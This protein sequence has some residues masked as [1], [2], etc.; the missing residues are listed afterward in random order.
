MRSWI[1][2]PYICWVCLLNK[3]EIS[4]CYCRA[5][6]CFW[7]KTVRKKIQSFS[8]LYLFFQMQ[9]VNIINVYQKQRQAFRFQSG[10]TQSVDIKERWNDR[11]LF[12]IRKQ[13]LFDLKTLLG[14]PNAP[15]DVE[16]GYIAPSCNHILLSNTWL[17][18][19]C[20]LNR[21]QDVQV[22][23]RKTNG[24][25]KEITMT[26][27]R[28]YYAENLNKTSLALMVT[29]DFFYIFCSFIIKSSKNA[30]FRFVSQHDKIFILFLL[31]AWPEYF[32][33]KNKFQIPLRIKCPSPKRHID[34]PREGQVPFFCQVIDG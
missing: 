26:K 4:N 19:F 23:S 5:M 27:P 20:M 1:H 25:C 22:Y 15:L 28:M 33:L 6:T 24:Q 30:I 18:C 10:D 31:M 11:I 32:F 7:Y 21:Q 2:L 13:Y 29:S 16:I 8:I 9:I 17:V 12:S 3:C 34:G 14:P